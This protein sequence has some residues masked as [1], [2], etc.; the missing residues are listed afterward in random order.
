MDLPASVAPYILRGLTLAGIDSVMRPRRDRIAAGDLLVR[1]LD[2]S[3]L[4][5]ATRE[6][7]LD[8]VVQTAKQPTLIRPGV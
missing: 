8:S 3:I 4:K 6:I 5:E 7:G 2:I 1:D